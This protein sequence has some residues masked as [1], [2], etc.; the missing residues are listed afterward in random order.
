M[1]YLKS[2]WNTPA[3]LVFTVEE[4][5]ENASGN[6]LA[7]APTSINLLPSWLILDC[8]IAGNCTATHPCRQIGSKSNRTDLTGIRRRKCLED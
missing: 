4:R 5:F 7:D 8:Q 1:Q 2:K 3:P 6:E